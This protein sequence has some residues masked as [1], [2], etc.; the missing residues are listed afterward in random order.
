M[1][2]VPVTAQNNSDD[3]FKMLETE[4]LI[5]SEIDDNYK[6]MTVGGYSNPFHSN[7]GDTSSNENDITNQFFEALGI[8]SDDIFD[9][10]YFSNTSSPLSCDK[11]YNNNNNEVEEMVEEMISKSISPPLPCYSGY[12]YSSNPYTP[13]AS[14]QQA[15]SP[16]AEP[17]FGAMS[18]HEILSLGL[19]ISELIAHD[20]MGRI[21]TCHDGSRFLQNVID[22]SLITLLLNHLIARHD[23]TQLSE[24]RYG[25]YSIQ[26]LFEKGSDFDHSQLLNAFMYANVLRLSRS[27][28]GCRVIQR[29][30]QCISAIDLIKELVF[31]L[32]RQASARPGAM[33]E[34]LVDANANHVIQAIINL[35][36]PFQNIEFLKIALES[37]F[38]FYCKHAFACRIVQCFIKKYG[39]KLAVN[40]LFENNGHLS[41]CQSMYGNYVVQ[42]IIK[43][44]VWYCHLKGISKFRWKLITELFR[45]ENVLFLSK[46]KFGSNVMESCVRVS[47]EKQID[48]LIQVLCTRN[49]FVINQMIKHKF[50]NYVI[51][52]LLNNATD[53]QQMQLVQ[54][55]EASWKNNQ[56]VYTEILLLEIDRIKSIKMNFGYQ[57]RGRRPAMHHG[58]R[59]SARRY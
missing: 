15:V 44:N 43:P 18:V 34:C 26:S 12:T 5:G 37:N 51:K 10:F 50:G 38:S 7:S 8:G 42:C 49:L 20:L 21:I 52:T 28:Y 14:T 56:N 54:T 40:K 45:G 32:K 48:G 17:D 22:S 11:V 30:L 19:S 39:D 36:L 31:R 41:A 29:A 4:G 35:E 47:T 46:N 33:D 13:Y 57:K 3:V 55:I 16:A 53:K 58:W 6:K 25:N 1:T 27:E 23:L 59:R 9:Q 2:D 24:D